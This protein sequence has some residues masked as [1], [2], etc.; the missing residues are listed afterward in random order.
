M[1]LGTR[2]D[3][4]PFVALARGL[5]EAGHE[6]LVCGP[7]RFEDFVVGRGVEF[8]GV[9]D[10]P[11]H[12]MDSA[13]GAGEAIQGGARARVRQVRQMPVMFE[14]VLADCWRVASGAG[15]D[16][17][18]VIH[19]GQVLAGQHIAEALGVPAA[20]GTPLPMYVPT[21]EFPWPG[22]T[23]PV[24]TPR[25]ANRMRY[26]GMKLPN[27]VF[28][29]VIERWR[30]E[31]LG[32][33]RRRGRHDPRQ[34]PD[35]VQAPVLHAFSP[36]VLPRPTDWPATAQVTGYWF[37]DDDVPLPPQVEHFIAAGEAPVFAGFGS[38]SGLDPRAVAELDVAA[39][40]RT[41]RRLV[42]GPG[43]GGLDGDVAQTAAARLGVELCVV[44]DVDH[45]A[46][47]PQMAAVVHHG[48]AGTT[49]TAFA[50]GRPQVVCPFV[51]DQPFWGEVVRARGVGPAPLPQRRMTADSLAARIELALDPRTEAAAAQLG[52]QI[53]RED[54]VAA[55][56]AAV[57]RAA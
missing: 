52:A 34:R 28:R 24:S 23:L 11:M 12:Q 50:A 32:L 22:Q 44:H 14:Q 30:H 17:D 31:S 2:G 42:L 51:A 16:A 8:S 39:A 53:G 38:V 7:H 9:D 43:W 21:R 55:A 49:G 48:G 26:A 18:L 15:A 54:G 33:P 3:V 41:E 36:S 6:A 4:Q 5:A 57:I 47:F 29:R 13:A 40:A 37:P 46:L 25:W 19:N 35:G 45:R 1:T 10:G 27:L 20:L 56:V